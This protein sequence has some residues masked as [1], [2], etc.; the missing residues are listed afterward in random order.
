MKDRIVQ[1][2]LKL[3]VE[4]IFEREFCESSYGFRPKRRSKDAL[5]EVNGLIESGYTHVV[6]ADLES[7]FDS[8][9]QEA[10]LARVGERISDTRVLDLVAKFVQ[11]D[12][13]QGLERWR[14]MSGTP[15]GGV[16][17]PL[18]ANLYLHPLDELLRARGYRMVR[19][20]DDFVV[21]CETAEQAQ[22]ALREVQAWVAANGLTSMRTRPTL[23]IVGARVKA[24][25]FWA[26]ALKRVAGR[27]DARACTACA[28]ASACIPGAPTGTACARSSQG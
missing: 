16:I 13:M 4:P 8:I 22:A 14:P 9:P 17:S 6:D 2:A 28:S 1:T 10:L 11:Q 24:S 27:F 23:G 19:Y 7:Y 25:S 15:Q 3:V 18:L 12:V 5:R 21:L 20:A 26:T